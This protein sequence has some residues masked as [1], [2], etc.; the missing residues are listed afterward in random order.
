MWGSVG[1]GSVAALLLACV[2][3]VSLWRLL[4]RHC[5][6]ARLGRSDMPTDMPIGAPPPP[7]QANTPQVPAAV[8]A[9]RAMESRARWVVERPRSGQQ[10]G[11]SNGGASQD[12]GSQDGSMLGGA[13]ALVL[14]SGELTPPLQESPPPSPLVD[15]REPAGLGA[16]GRDVGGHDAG[17][18]GISHLVVDDS[19]IVE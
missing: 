8:H 14:A 13:M 16:L 10:V 3:V 17:G 18:G 1:G 2:G 15:T 6:Y 7:S 4:R 5:L 11:A 19:E 9:M 12:G